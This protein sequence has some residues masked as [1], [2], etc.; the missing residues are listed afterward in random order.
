MR[1][2]LSVLLVSVL[3]LSVASSPA[4]GVSGFGDVD[5]DKYFTEPVQWMV[6]NSITGGTSPTC[7]SPGDPVTRGQAAAFLWRMEDSPTGSP[8]HTFTDVIAAW[9]QVPVSWMV[10]N[11][12]TTGTTT[13][14]YSPDDPVTRGQVAAFLWRLA[15]SPVAPPPTQFTDVVKSWQITPVGWMVQQEITTGTSTSE[16][17]PEDIVT[18]GQVATFLYRYKGSP[19][20]VVDPNHPAIPV[21][22]AQVPGPATTGTLNILTDTTLIQNHNGE[23]DIGADNVI[24]DCAGHSVT[25]KGSGTGINVDGRTGVTVR[26]CHVSGFELGVVLSSSSSN[27]IDGNWVQE[28]GLPGGLS[29]GILLT[30]S[31]DNKISNNAVTGNGADGI[32]IGS[33]SDGNTISDNNVTGNGIHGISLQNADNNT[34]IGNESRD[35]EA[36]GIW[37]AKSLGNTVTENSATGNGQFGIDDSSTGGTG[38]AGT[39]NNYT[40]NTCS[41]NGQGNSLPYGLCW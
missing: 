16:F 2:R 20:V 5:A 30:G 23:I 4:G 32:A 12:I 21:C 38:D 25:G 39:D 33:S 35:N 8:P 7:F 17:S 31:P 36:V 37:V 26:R 15:G 18:R 10:D 19:A 14:T 28:N 6:D 11:D 13:T 34:L 22:S 27:I 24:L 9:Q 29:I 1:A 3:V 41:G 40:N